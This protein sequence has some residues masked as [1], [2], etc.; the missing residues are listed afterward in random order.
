MS[1]FKRWLTGII[2]IFILVVVVV[3]AVFWKDIQEI[4]GALEYA[5]PVDP[6]TIVEN[7]R[8]LYKKYPST[9]INRHIFNLT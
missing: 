7:F 1:R 5:K 4:R 6:D 3:L 9:T 2:S 8:S